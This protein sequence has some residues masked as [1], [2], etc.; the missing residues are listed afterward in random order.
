MTT[1]GRWKVIDL[2][3][4]AGGMSYGFHAHKGFQI[5]G[6]ADAQVGKPSSG[7]GSLDCN[8]TYERNIGI[9]PLEVDLSKIG[10]DELFTRFGKV[11]PTI[12]IAC[13]PCTGF[14]RTLSSN[15]LA[16]D[17]RNSLVV[18]TAD[19]VRAFSPEIFLMENARELLQGNHTHHFELLS[20]QL[21]AMDYEVDAQTH[22]LNR[23]GLPQKRER[24]IVIAAKRPLQ[25]RSLDDLWQNRSINAKS[26]TVRRAIA[27]LCEMPAGQCDP[28]D[29]FHTSPSFT[30]VTRRR[31]EAIPKNGGSWLDLR[32]SPEATELMTPA[33]KNYIAAGKFGSHPDVYGRMWWD[34]PAPTIKRECGHTG[35]GRYAHP[36]QNRLCTVRE[37]AI[38]QGFPREFQFEGTSL[39]NMYRHIG[40]A[41]PPLVA[42]QIAH[43]CSWMLTGIEPDLSCTV[44]PNTHLAASDI[45]HIGGQQ[46]LHFVGS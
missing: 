5:I 7:V 41:V 31:L 24:A 44:L 23:F 39:S 14:S 34:R 9:K 12:L 22:F 27:D 19:F 29:P 33:M 25:I 10:S 30:D 13:S 36:N 38:L 32:E 40:D 17:P 1:E 6:A 21:R 8:K 18:K 37:M 20:E 43:V 3:S 16:D 28:S 46:M 4:G 35:N 45:R 26:T 2:F 15:H 42:Y 11:S